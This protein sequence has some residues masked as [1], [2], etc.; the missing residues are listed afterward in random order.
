LEAL[1]AIL[2]HLAVTAADPDATARFYIDA[3]HL[4]P[5]S[6][7]RASWGR[8]HVLTDGTI[9][10]S[11]LE[12]FDDAAAGWA[13]G[14]GALGL[15]HI[16]FEVA[17]LEATG[18]RVCEAG[19]RPRADIA[20]ALGLDANARVGEFEGP[21]SVVFDLGAPDVWNVTPKT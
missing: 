17:D 19:G 18:R 3:L 1:V 20:D 8:G 7:F 15:H 13:D 5:L 11:V 6:S 14:D 21:D 16:G 12:Y 4:T 9:S 10:L 2:R